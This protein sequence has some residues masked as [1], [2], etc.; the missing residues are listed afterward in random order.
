MTTT[1]QV[2]D[3]TIEDLKTLKEQLN[4]GSYDA[5]MKFFLKKTMKPEKSMWGAYGKM[6]MKEILNGLRD[7]TDR[8]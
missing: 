6:T 7:E 1:I 3:D 4:F 2:N 8:Y 5:L